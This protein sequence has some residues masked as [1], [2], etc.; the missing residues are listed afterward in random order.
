MHFANGETPPVKAFWSLTMYDPQY[1]F[2]ANPLNKYTVSPR[3]ALKYNPDGS[4]DVYVQNQS[5]GGE[6]EANWLPAPT[7]DFILMM[8]LY[9][10]Q[11]TPP[12]IIDGSWIVP[13]V[14][15]TGG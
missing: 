1:F 11:E 6:W 5:P 4:L 14:I 8:R 9:W 13:P 7:G 15:R 3:N 2:V 12:S 10:P